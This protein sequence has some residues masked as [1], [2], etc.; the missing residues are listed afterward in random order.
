MSSLTSNSQKYAKASG[1]SNT[2][3]HRFF[4]GQWV[5]QFIGGGY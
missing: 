3:I 4:N 2:E 1:I 5:N